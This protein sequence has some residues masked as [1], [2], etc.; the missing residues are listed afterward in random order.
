M[1]VICS[2]FVQHTYKN[3]KSLCLTFLDVYW[4]QIYMHDPVGS[5][6]YVKKYGNVKIG[7]QSSGIF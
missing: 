3:D 1:F 4:E 2:Y 6:D 7:V 5:F